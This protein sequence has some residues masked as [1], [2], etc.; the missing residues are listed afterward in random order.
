MVWRYLGDR[1]TSREA[2]VEVVLRAVGVFMTE[3]GH[4]ESGWPVGSD[5]PQRR[6]ALPR[7][8]TT[9]RWTQRTSKNKQNRTLTRVRPVLDVSR[10][11][12]SGAG[13]NRTPV[14][15]PVNGPDTTIPDFKPDAGL[16]AG[17]LTFVN[18]RTFPEVSCLSRRQRSFSSSS[19]ASVAGL[20]WIG[21]VR[22]F[23][24]RCLFT[25]L[26]SGGESELLIGNSLWCPVS[27]V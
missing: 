13:G 26:R 25:H 3:P 4:S 19:P 5:Q 2:V 12:I 7:H 8:R 21:P 27:R 23:W 17:R 22:H 24:S 14:H 10:H 15:Q 20:R 6:R 1:P 16:S 18:A 9:L 11:H